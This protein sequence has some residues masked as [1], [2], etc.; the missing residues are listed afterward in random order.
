MSLHLTSSTRS[1]FF[2][3][4]LPF[5][6]NLFPR[7][8]FVFTFLSSFHSPP[9]FTVYL[10]SLVAYY[11]PF[12]LPLSSISLA[13]LPL[14]NSYQRSPCFLPSFLL[15]YLPCFLYSFIFASFI[16]IDSFI[17]LF[18]ESPFLLASPQ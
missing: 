1:S 6:P 2:S 12:L 14:C 4:S 5:L 13:S 16:H 10:I 9:F 8:S 18:F 7:R 15:A 17:Y 11:P 3:P